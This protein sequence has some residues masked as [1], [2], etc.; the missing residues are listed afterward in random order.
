MSLLWEVLLCKEQCCWS[1]KLHLMPW[2]MN[3]G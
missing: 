3:Q 2:P 1:I